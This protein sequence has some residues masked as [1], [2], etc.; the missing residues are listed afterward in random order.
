MLNNHAE[1]IIAQ[2]TRIADALERHPRMFPER[3]SGLAREVGKYLS[4]ADSVIKV[5][6]SEGSK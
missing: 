1:Q 2:L 5:H 3:A 6:T 4:N